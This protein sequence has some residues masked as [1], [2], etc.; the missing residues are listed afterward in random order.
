MKVQTKLILGFLIIYLLFGITV[1]ISIYNIS[2][3]LEKSASDNLLIYTHG[4]MEQIDK[5]INE[6]IEDFK[7]YSKDLELQE[8]LKQSNNE[9]EKLSDV[10]S[11]ITQKDLEWN[12]TQKIEIT[13]FMKNLID[14]RI[15]QQLRQKTKFYESDYGYKLYGEVFITNKY[16]AN[17]AETGKTTDYRQ[18]DENWWQR[19]KSDGVYVEDVKY[20]QSADVYS[21]AISIRVDDDDGNFIGVI[22]V[23]LN[24]QGVINVLKEAETHKRFSSMEFILL[25]EKDRILFSTTNYELLQPFSFFSKIN[26]KNGLFK[27]KDSEGIEKIGAYSSSKGY[28]SFKGLGWIITVDVDRSEILN[29]IYRLVINFLA[30]AVILIVIAGAVG[31]YVY[32]SISTSLEKFEKTID[33]ISKGSLDARVEIKSKDEF[34]MLALAFNSMADQ[35]KS[36]KR[37][38]KKQKLE[39]ELEA[40]EASHK[41]GFISDDSY[42]K[43]RKRLEEGII[44]AK[45]AEGK[46]QEKVGEFFK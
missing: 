6:R 35:L 14:N 25:D 41:I 7:I 44:R 30:L 23:V 32:S 33:L 13:P 29:P 8:F 39:K 40:L 45:S 17:A 11:Y 10:Q 19:G 27:A 37:V 1:L 15:S 9:F 16:G 31:F 20:D 22:K 38:E 34:Y 24:I 3:I 12:S 2:N 26:G 5:H 21:T 18:D 36:F 28:K 43:E 42:T 46:L 4:L